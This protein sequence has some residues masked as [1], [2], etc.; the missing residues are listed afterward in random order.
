MARYMAFLRAINVGGRTVKMDRLRELFEA[1][2]F[3]DVSTFI[4]SGNVVFDAPEQGSGRAW[5]GGSRSTSLQSLG[6][7]VATFLRTPAELAAIAAFQPFPAEGPEAER[8]RLYVMLLRA[9]LGLESA[10]A[11]PVAPHRGG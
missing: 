8:H 4:A 2:K 3:T 11:A 9:P 7:E 10:G 5:R 1:M 6:Y